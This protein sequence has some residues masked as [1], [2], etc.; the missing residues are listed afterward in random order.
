MTLDSSKNN[1]PTDY[2]KIF[3]VIRYH[4][5]YQLNNNGPVFLSYACNK[6]IFPSLVIMSVVENLAI[7]EK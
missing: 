1:Q 6:S 3:Y 7:G 5:F 2:G 4:T